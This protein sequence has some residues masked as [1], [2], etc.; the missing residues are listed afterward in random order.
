MISVI[1]VG[2]IQ[3]LNNTFE[4]ISESPQSSKVQDGEFRT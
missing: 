4:G 2:Y 3:I 1:N